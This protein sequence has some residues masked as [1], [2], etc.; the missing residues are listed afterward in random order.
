MRS[1]LQSYLFSLGNFVQKNPGKVLF[2]G[3]LLLSTFSVVLKS[4]RIE[5]RVEKLWVE[6]ELVLGGRGENGQLG[7]FHSG[8]KRLF[9]GRKR[10]S[11][12]QSVGRR[13]LR[14]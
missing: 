7:N 6:G 14:H 9:T 11:I 5:W 8:R 4:P 2:F 13:L 3:I 10:R 1:K 12:G